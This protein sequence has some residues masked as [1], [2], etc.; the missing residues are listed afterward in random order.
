LCL[1][2]G[3]CY[4]PAPRRLAILFLWVEYSGAM[5]SNTRQSVILAALL[6]LLVFALVYLWLIGSFY[7]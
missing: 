7:L 5:K 1:S 4:A 6:A 2:K 3:A